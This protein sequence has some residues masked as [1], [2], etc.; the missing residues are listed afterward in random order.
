MCAVQTEL[1]FNKES[2]IE[3]NVLR[4]QIINSES[5]VSQKW[6]RA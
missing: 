6:R 2:K 1:N 5:V 3:Q 4:A